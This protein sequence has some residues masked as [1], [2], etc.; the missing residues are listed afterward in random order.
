MALK[1]VYTKYI[2]GQSITFS[3]AYHQITYISGNK[4]SIDLQVTIF[5]TDQ[6]QNIIDRKSYRFVP[7]ILDTATNFYKQGYDYLKTTVEY[8][9]AIDVLEDGQTAA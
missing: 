3:E 2:Y 4:N 5:D 7:S 8:D 6:K 1:K 9:N